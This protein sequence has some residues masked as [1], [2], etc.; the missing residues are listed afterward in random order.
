MEFRR[1][2]SDDLEAVLAL[3]GKGV[4]FHEALDADR[5]GA[6]PDILKGYGRWLAQR[7][8]DPRSCVLVTTND[9]GT[10]VAMLIASVEQ[11]I[12]I[13]RVTEFGYVHELWVEDAYR[14]E[15]IARQL[16]AMTIEHFITIGVEQIRLETAAQNDAARK[17]FEQSGFRVATVDMLWTAR[18]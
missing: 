10:V 18:R 5:F 12:P 2:T 16:V 4:A 8:V 11:A 1:A 15:G 7:I 3:V 14:N 6:K 13:Y 17:L 9:C